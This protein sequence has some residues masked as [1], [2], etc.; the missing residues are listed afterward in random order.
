MEAVRAAVQAV[1]DLLTP[2]QAAYI[3]KKLENPRMTPKQQYAAQEYVVTMDDKKLPNIA[4]P[5]VRDLIKEKLLDWQAVSL[6]KGEYVREY[7]HSI[8]ELCPTDHF[9]LAEDGEWAID[10]EKFRELPHNVKR[11]V[12]SVETRIVRGRV[13]YSVKF[14]SKT[15]ALAMAA[16]YTLTQSVEVTSKQSPPWEVIAGKLEQ[17]AQKSI[18]T[19][20]DDVDAEARRQVQEIRAESAA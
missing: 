10:P 9:I 11:L 6:L 14:L 1:I 15:A 18:E 12:E 16:K 13:Y 5:A 19:I 20:I 17:R 2:E 3:Q 4:N 8:L 7:I